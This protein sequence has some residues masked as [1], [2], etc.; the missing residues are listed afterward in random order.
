DGSDAR[1]VAECSHASV[2]QGVMQQWLG[3]THRLGWQV[4]RPD[5]GWKVL[6]L[7]TEKQWEGDGQVRTF[8]PDGTKAFLQTP[9]SLHLEAE[10]QGKTLAPEDVGCK[11]I[12]W[13]TEEL[14]L[15]ISVADVLE[16]HPEAEQV[17]NQH[18]I[19]KQT[20]FSPD[21]NRI[22]FN[23]SNAWYARHRD[24]ERRHEKLVANRDGT[25]I[26]YLGSGATHPSWHP[27][28]KYY[29]AVKHDENGVPRFVLYPVD[30]SEPQVLGPDWIAGGHPSFQPGDGR[31]MAVDYPRRHRGDV[32]LRI[33]DLQEQT[34][35][36]VLLAEYTD[37]SNKSGTHFHPAWSSD[38]R[39][40]FISTA[41]TGIAGLYRLDL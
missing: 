21:G 8:S 35:E 25:D 19:F 9:E 24:E 36:D 39:S 2:C 28:G 16:V 22:S 31:Y 32:L 37:Y 13:E 6:D 11:I 18:M 33:F 41:H 26:T 27:T 38:G 3:P 4:R 30:G 14:E 12:D 34:W 40:I 29:H 1:T 15:R 23:F 7:D 17:K 5:R 20:L 10:E